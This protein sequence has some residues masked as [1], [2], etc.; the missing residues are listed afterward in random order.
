MK[1]FSS[2]VAA[3][4]LVA[5]VGA[6]CVRPEPRLTGQ[7]STPNQVADT[8][9]PMGILSLSGGVATVTRGNDTT[10]A[11][12]GVELEAGDM[13]AVTTGTA[14]IVYP[15]T[16][17]S[18]LPAGT[19]VTVL[20]DGEGDGSVFVQVDLAAG[21]IWSRFERL[22][23]PDEKFSVTGNG[24]V[25]TVRGT[26]FGM[27]LVNGQ[28][29]VLVAD[30]NVDVTTFA[31]RKASKKAVHLQAGQ[32]MRIAAQ[33]MA[34]L[35][36]AGMKKLVRSLGEKD[37]GRG[38]FKKMSTTVPESVMKMKAVKK[39]KGAPTIPEQ[40]QDRIDPAMLERIMVTT[41]GFVAPTRMVLPGEIA[42]TTKP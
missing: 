18:Y 3:V 23:G 19:I 14:M 25:A 6:G 35:D 34:K 8:I 31:D 12:E 20:P 39:M 30:H 21:S 26:A 27:E 4:A 38:E 17:V 22:F 2:F 24:V 11:E 16:G 13:V 10:V 32:G 33:A 29:D 1:Y 9:A 7:P 36:T 15:E 5:V 41:T 28:A 40:F 42:P 37:K